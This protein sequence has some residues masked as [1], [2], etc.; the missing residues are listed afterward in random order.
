MLG[1]FLKTE[2]LDNTISLTQEIKADAARLIQRHNEAKAEIARLQS[3][4]DRLNTVAE[5][6]KGAVAT[7]NNRAAS[8]RN[9]ALE[10]AAH[11][12][13]CDGHAMGVTEAVAAIRALKREASK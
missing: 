11:L 12:I 9:D 2:R 8:A 3:E 10:E 4:V 1:R 5:F 7:A 6:W 13:E